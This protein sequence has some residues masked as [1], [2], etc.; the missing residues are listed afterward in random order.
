[1]ND[2]DSQDLIALLVLS[3]MI[4]TLQNILVSLLLDP[5]TPVMDRIA[6]R[7]VILSQLEI[8]KADSTSRSIM[9]SSTPPSMISS[10]I[11]ALNSPFRSDSVV[12]VT[13]DPNIIKL[14]KSGM[15]KLWAV[16]T[17]TRSTAAM[18]FSDCL[19]K[20]PSYKIR[21]LLPPGTKVQ[22]QIIGRGGASSSSTSSSALPT[23]VVIRATDG[24]FV[25]KSWFVLALRV[26]SPKILSVYPILR[27]RQHSR[28]QTC[29]NLN[30]KPET[31]RKVCSNSAHQMTVLLVVESRKPFSSH[32]NGQRKPNGAMMEARRSVANVTNQH[33]FH[34][35]LATRLAARI[36]IPTKPPCS[37]MKSTLSIMATWPNWIVDKLVC[38]K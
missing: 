30:T 36:L 12:R 17:P 3:K 19:D 11:L 2:I 32:W 1:M 6:P 35:T 14:E 27:P 8:S 22:V 10:M 16:E 9:A 20:S 21:K 34:P 26:S 13:T 37:I 7:E 31:N 28:L 5:G 25:P 23:A 15:V 4:P 29:N 18:P 33:P 24:Q 38:R